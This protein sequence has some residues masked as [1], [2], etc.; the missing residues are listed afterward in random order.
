MLSKEKTM[1]YGS[2]FN[3]PTNLKPNVGENPAL[4][5]QMGKDAG[6]LQSQRRVSEA[7]QGIDS[8]QVSNEELGKR[9]DSLKAQRMQLESQLNQTQ[10]EEQAVEQQVRDAPVFVNPPE[11]N[12]RADMF[13][14]QQD[15]TLRYDPTAPTEQSLFGGSGAPVQYRGNQPSAAELRRTGRF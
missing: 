14:P 13:S 2:K 9:L 12:Y 10:M 6:K 5:Y 15:Q 3:L 1:P 4:S 8:N 7:M 11:G